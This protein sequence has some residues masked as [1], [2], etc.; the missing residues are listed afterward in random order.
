MSKSDF[1]RKC[2]S[3]YK[4]TGLN[5]SLGLHRPSKTLMFLGLPNFYS[6]INMIETL[7]YKQWLN[8]LKDHTVCC[9]ATSVL[10]H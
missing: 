4:R 2:S 5:S 6:I 8:P 7:E 1:F 9:N 3:I 10:N